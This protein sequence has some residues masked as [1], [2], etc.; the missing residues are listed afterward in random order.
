MVSAKKYLQLDPPA[1][2]ID[3]PKMVR[4]GND[5]LRQMLIFP[6]S[7]TQRR[8]CRTTGMAPR[9]VGRLFHTGDFLS[10]AWTKG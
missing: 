3:D 2:A 6:F 9:G 7:R 4:E 5:V 10:I 1:V 8:P